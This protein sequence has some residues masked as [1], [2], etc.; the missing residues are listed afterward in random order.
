MSIC[1]TVIA[2]RCDTFFVSVA[3]CLVNA[4]RFFAQ[5]YSAF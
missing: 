5:R 4:R 3:S 2:I 1:C